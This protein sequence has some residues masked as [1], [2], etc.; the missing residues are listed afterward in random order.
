MRLRV[1]KLQADMEMN[2]K[3]VSEAWGAARAAEEQQVNLDITIVMLKVN[4]MHFNYP[5]AEQRQRLEQSNTEGA[6][7][8]KLYV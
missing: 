2:E 6:Q 7:V 4:P 5:P 8:R 3:F 1:R